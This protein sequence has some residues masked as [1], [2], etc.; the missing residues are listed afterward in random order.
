[1]FTSGASTGTTT[2]FNLTASEAL[3][4]SRLNLGVF[5]T[6]SDLCNVGQSLVVMN[7]GGAMGSRV[8]LNPSLRVSE[9]Y[10]PL[11]NYTGA[12]LEAVP[13]LPL[14][15]TV[16]TAGSRLAFTLGDFKGY[17]S[18]PWTLC[19]KSGLVEMEG[20]IN[21]SEMLNGSTISGSNATSPT[22]NASNT[23]GSNASVS[24]EANVTS[25]ATS[26]SVSS[27]WVPFGQMHVVG[28]TRR[29]VNCNLGARCAVEIHGYGNFAP[30]SNFLIA[31][32][33]EGNATATR[34][35]TTSL[36][37]ASATEVGAGNSSTSTAKNAEE[38]AANDCD[39]PEWMSVYDASSEFTYDTQAQTQT[40]KL[41]TPFANMPTTNADASTLYLCWR[42]SATTS[43]SA[44]TTSS[45]SAS[46]STSPPSSTIN[47]NLN[48]FMALPGMKETLGVSSSYQSQNQFTRIGQFVVSGPVLLG[49]G[50]GQH[51]YCELGDH[52]CDIQLNYVGTSP[53]LQSSLNISY[54]QLQPVLGG[55]T[56]PDATVVNKCI[57]GTRVASS[58][59]LQN[60][61]RGSSNFFNST[62]DLFQLGHVKLREPVGWTG[63]YRTYASSAN[64][65]HQHGSSSAMQ[66]LQ[67]SSSGAS[68]GYRRR[69]S[70]TAASA[71]T[72]AHDPS[73]GTME[74]DHMYGYLGSMST[75]DQTKETM[76]EL[77]K[78]WRAQYDGQKQYEFQTATTGEESG[79]FYD[80]GRITFVGPLET[81]IYCA[82]GEMCEAMNVSGTYLKNTPSRSVSIVVRDDATSFGD[83]ECQR[84]FSLSMSNSASSTGM[85]LEQHLL[86]GLVADFADAVGGSITSIAVSAE[87]D[88]FKNPVSQLKS[89]SS[90]A[91]SSEETFSVLFGI[92]ERGVAGEYALCWREREVF[93]TFHL[94]GPL[95]GSARPTTCPLGVTDCRLRIEG[96]ALAASNHLRI[97]E[98]AFP[99]QSVNFLPKNPVQVTSDLRHRLYSF[100]PL[101]DASIRP[102][103]YSVFWGQTPN[104]Q[105]VS[106]DVVVF[107]GPEVKSLTA[108]DGDTG[109]SCVLG[110]ECRIELNG[111][112]L[113]SFNRLKVLAYDRL[114]P[115]RVYNAPVQTVGPNG[116][117]V[118]TNLTRMVYEW[119][120]Q[121]T[122][123]LDDVE[124]G[125]ATSNTT[126]NSTNASTTTSSTSSGSVT[127]LDTNWTVTELTNDGIEKSVDGYLG[128]PYNPIHPESIRRNGAS[129][130]FGIPLANASRGYRLYWHVHSKNNEAATMLDAK[131]ASEW[132]TAGSFE[133]LGPIVPDGT[134]NDLM[135]RFEHEAEGFFYPNAISNNSNMTNSAANPAS[136]STNETANASSTSSAGNNS[137]VV[138]LLSSALDVPAT[139]T[140]STSTS[141]S[142]HYD[143]HSCVIGKTC[144]I[145]VEFIGRTFVSNS[146]RIRHACAFNDTFLQLKAKDPLSDERFPEDAMLP[147]SAG[148]RLLEEEDGGN[149]GV[150][151][152]LNPGRFETHIG[153]GVAD[154]DSK[155]TASPAV[156]A[157]EVDDTDLD[158]KLR[159]LSHNTPTTTPAPLPT[160]LGLSFVPNFLPY[161][162]RPTL[163]D[164]KQQ[165]YNQY[166][167]AKTGFRNYIPIG[168]PGAVSSDNMGWP[169]RMFET[170]EHPYDPSWSRPALVVDPVILPEVRDLTLDGGF[171]GY[172]ETGDLMDTTTYASSASTSGSGTGVSPSPTQ[173]D[174]LK[175]LSSVDAATGQAVT[176]ETLA[177]TD[178][179]TEY[180]TDLLLDSLE[181]QNNEHTIT[182]LQN[183]TVFK[184]DFGLATT[185]PTFTDY[186]LCWSKNEVILSPLRLYGPVDANLGR[187]NRC[188]FTFPAATSPSREDT[189]ASN[190][191]TS[192][193]SNDTTN[194][195]S[196]TAGGDKDDCLFYVAGD[197]FPIQ[198]PLIAAVDTKNASSS[199]AENS[200][201]ESSS[202][203]SSG[204]DTVPTSRGSNK[205][206]F[207][208]IVDDYDCSTSTSNVILSGNLETVA[209]TKELQQPSSVPAVVEESDY[210]GNGVTTFDDMANPFGADLSRYNAQQLNQLNVMNQYVTLPENGVLASEKRAV[211]RLTASEDLRK[212][213][214]KDNYTICWKHEN[215]T[216]D[217][218][219]RAGFLSV[220]TPYTCVL[221]SLCAL[222][223][224]ALTTNAEKSLSS[225][226]GSFD[227]ATD[228]LEYEFS[229]SEDLSCST[230]ATNTTLV[231]VLN[232]LENAANVETVLKNLIREHLVMHQTMSDTPENA[233]AH[234]TADPRVLSELARRNS[235]LQSFGFKKLLLLPFVAGVYSLCMAVH[236]VPLVL[237]DGTSSSSSNIT[238]TSN[239]ASSTSSVV[240]MPKSAQGFLVVDG[241]MVPPCNRQTTR[242]PPRLCQHQHRPIEQTVG[243]TVLSSGQGIMITC[244]R[245]V[246][247]LLLVHTT[248][249]R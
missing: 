180:T 11:S 146:M 182:A 179:S 81:D 119:A 197:F 213:R 1:M 216:E 104:A 247:V 152:A 156:A 97:A 229:V 54:L 62:S 121:I 219:V 117:V 114:E 226:S 232:G 137:T 239:N 101:N 233:I 26:S 69:R 45:P 222:D 221:G 15:A 84:A 41:D 99:Y 116:T 172:V 160:P 135:H 105:K 188:K 157:P 109:F 236:K 185:L 209:R 18:G 196:S 48:P 113:Q 143:F 32:K 138:S 21:S 100:G 122:T 184:Y 230:K 112:A 80:I 192:G 139:T 44:D 240:L 200:P 181:V 31:Q 234:T 130:S 93:G 72:G 218:W 98:S 87:E 118:S 58:I 210:Y 14:Y 47:K 248:L 38:I 203:N 147:Y 187:V 86:D 124:E 145:A 174:L 39:G 92:P 70:L 25:T 95:S 177:T 235:L 46:S 231:K 204:N 107:Q 111:V 90:G 155:Q 245:R 61:F 24:S 208:Q 53:G 201:S 189:S 73:S 193:T 102:G 7:L 227:N 22:K 37:Y 207:I 194:S 134:V 71:G 96:H 176:R 12:T 129:F 133:I 30:I 148:R 159:R 79:S 40:I 42:A 50:Q 202:T 27:L 142:T 215:V 82:L 183:R 19:W 127:T 163:A 78:R 49:S 164:L 166:E 125:L 214:R 59:R 141:T 151:D 190:D 29:L 83:A 20:G 153:V 33:Q 67:S 169:A 144:S 64:S 55:E 9:N 16:D 57:D 66:E 108:P 13:E 205:K 223:V 161:G 65:A 170:S 23:S 186:E 136:S 8:D 224:E 85:T 241:P 6:E 91:T 211:M 128:F 43:S 195:S 52:E 167:N 56:H 68:G 243:S 60:A 191:T 5:Q 103:I 34:R 199:S 150:E 75:F 242:T 63:T 244:K 120:P 2:P 217:P 3:L 140:T 4:R 76:D 110:E 165:G 132:I 88:T 35:L 246:V 77:Q 89:N 212:F 115:T 206:N 154:I 228:R 173:E 126:N 131:I 94:T 178:T 149:E 51:F 175:S 249:V 106:T 225:T 220:E 10:A 168:W 237:D 238:T 158:T 17:A 171:K 198:A 36:E 162:Y 74:E 123:L 28:P